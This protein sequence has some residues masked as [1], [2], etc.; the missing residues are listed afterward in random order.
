FNLLLVGENPEKI[1]SA[2]AILA[3]DI[4]RE[5]FL[6]FGEKNFIPLVAVD[7]VIDHPLFFQITT[8]Y[9]KLNAE[10]KAHFQKPF[11]FVCVKPSDNGVKKEIIDTF[12]NV[13][14][15]DTFSQIENIKNENILLINKFI[16]ENLNAKKFPNIYF[17][18][19]FVKMKMEQIANCLK[20]SMSHDKFDVHSY[21]I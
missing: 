4:G 10:A 17:C 12:E 13:S 5:E 15:I 11:T 21:K 8:D 16:Y 19:K 14:F 7:S 18:D 6:S 9:Q 1:T 2:D 3:Y 20:N